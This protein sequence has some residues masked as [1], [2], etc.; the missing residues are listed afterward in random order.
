[1]KKDT[2]DLVK[3]ENKE[4]GFTLV[5]VMVVMAILAVMVV[6]LIGILN[7][8]SL[9]GKAN[10]SRR[11]SD[12]NKI[13]TAF[14]E[15]FNDK[16]EYPLITDVYAWNVVS[17]CGTVIDEMKKYLNK[18][19]CDPKKQPYR[20]AIN[21][22]PR[23]FKAVTNLENKLDKNIPTD[24]YKEGTYPTSNFNKNEAN[25]G[26]S[27]SNVLWYETD[28]V[29]DCNS[30]YCYIGSNCNQASSFTGCNRERDNTEC[31]TRHNPTDACNYIGC[32]V[33]CCGV[34]C[35]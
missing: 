35:E 31:Y 24:W 23:W 20:I 3:I 33:P 1:M 11:K 29:P 4:S 34:G 9:I 7:P 32:L 16:G 14:E 22:N 21:N 8:I 6:I 28:I 18:W 12:L 10:D 19:P 5:E 25:Y 27:S 13:R 2:I 30:S 15:Y 26:V 17:N